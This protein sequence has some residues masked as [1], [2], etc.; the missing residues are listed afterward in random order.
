MP[1]LAARET[2]A[3]TAVEHNNTRRFFMNRFLLDSWDTD[4]AKT[5]D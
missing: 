5:G 1:A 3:I 4:D 2:T